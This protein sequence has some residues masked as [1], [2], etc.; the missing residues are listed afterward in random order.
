VP[1][2]DAYIGKL[3]DIGI[4]TQHGIYVS[5]I[6]FTNGALE[7]AKEVGLTPLVLTG[8]TP[9]H[10]SAK[11]DEAIQSV[12]YL[13][14]EITSF[15][16]HCNVQSTDNSS[17]LWFLYDETGEI[18]AA[19]PDLLW[20]KWIEGKLPAQLGEYEIEIE[21]PKGWKLLV[22]GNFQTITSAKAKVKITGVV[23]TV[24]GKAT[25]HAL[26]NPTDRGVQRFKT[27]ISFETTRKVY[28]VTSF[29]S[30]D[31]LSKFI[32]NRPE[33]I[34]LTIERIRLPRIKF[35][36]LYWPLSARAFTEFFELAKKCQ[37]EGR[38]ASGE[39]LA[40]I[41]GSDLKTIWDPMWEANPLLQEMFN[42]KS[43][44]NTGSN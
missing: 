33:S 15:I 42:L 24:Q 3:Q 9:D 13:L 18:R 12:I 19:I 10:L 22:D 29:S 34:K 4:P 44:E 21:I 23:M 14:P 39:E 27:D 30:E 25:Q 32:N 26:I 5:T 11:I 16:I 20:K 6:G 17:Q 31:D 40:K 8:L 2:I 35:S 28:P 1:Y 43:N 41:E 37:A 36:L 7:R 38:K